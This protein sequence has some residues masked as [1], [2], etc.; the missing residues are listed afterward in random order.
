MKSLPAEEAQ[1]SHFGLL[2]PYLDFIGLEPLEIGNDQAKT[3]LPY[4]RELVNSRGHLH[5]GALLSVLDFTL[6]A[7]GRSH[8]PL[9]VGVVTI[10]LSSNFLLPAETDL[11][12]VAR[13]IRRGSSICFCEGEI[14]NDEGRVIAK[15]MAS[16][17]LIKPRLT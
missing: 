1:R 3:R 12:C 5:G 8:D 7:A 4:R 14:L 9:N 6:S 16:F 13:C 10:D 2:I 11:I 17:K 15:A